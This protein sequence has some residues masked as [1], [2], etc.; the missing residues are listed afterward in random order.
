MRNSAASVATKK[1]STP[2][3]P[4]PQK[5]E[6]HQSF[7]EFEK[8]VAKLHLQE[9]WQINSL[10]NYYQIFKHGTIHGICIFDVYIRNNLEFTIRVFAV[11]ILANHEIYMKFS[12]S[13][14]NITLSNLF[15]E[16]SH[17]CIFEGIKNDI[18]FAIYQPPFYSKNI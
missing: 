2:F 3:L 12:K 14:K 4:S 8:R 15:Q 7:K 16:I 9:N 11:C 1:R 10:S 17:Y 5:V 18:F 6:C 13:I